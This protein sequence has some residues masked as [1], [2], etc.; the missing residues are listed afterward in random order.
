MHL[1]GARYVPD[2]G[3]Q[4]R[5]ADSHAAQTDAQDPFTGII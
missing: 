1:G 3:G 4:Q 2:S 5:R